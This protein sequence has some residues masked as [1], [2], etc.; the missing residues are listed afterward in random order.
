MRF[1]KFP[2]K[3][4]VLYV[5]LLGEQ[6]F[7][8]PQTLL[9]HVLIKSFF[10]S[11]KDCEHILTGKRYNPY[12]PGV[13]SKIAK[14]KVINVQSRWTLWKLERVQQLRQVAIMKFA[15]GKGSKPK[16]HVDVYDVYCIPPSSL[17]LIGQTKP[18]QY[19]R[20][21]KGLDVVFRLEKFSDLLFTPLPWHCVFFF[22]FLT[23]SI[24]LWYIS[25]F[26]RRRLLSMT[27][28]IEMG[29][30]TIKGW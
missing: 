29:N 4:S 9:S 18:K 12:R 24:M 23:T 15:G 6:S 8:I 7:P 13:S 25:L 22:M 19:F 1:E 27:E 2:Q 26:H 17:F 16:S 3:S 28:V 11:Q 14:S 5:F 10:L 30:L 20:A 21:K